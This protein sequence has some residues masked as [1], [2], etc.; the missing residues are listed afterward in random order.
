MTGVADVF[1]CSAAMYWEVLSPGIPTI[2]RYDS[3]ALTTLGV[4]FCSHA[5]SAE[6]NPSEAGRTREMSVGHGTKDGV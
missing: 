6:D 3:S 1:A 2:S 4:R 5:A